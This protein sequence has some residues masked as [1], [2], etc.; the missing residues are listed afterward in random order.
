MTAFDLEQVIGEDLRPEMP[1]N[2]PLGEN[3]TARPFSAFR[4]VP[5]VP[6][7]RVICSFADAVWLRPQA[8]RSSSAVPGPST[9]GPGP[10]FT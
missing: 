4:C 3:A 10:A 8:L 7:G 5:T 1:E 2:I 6:I 9:R